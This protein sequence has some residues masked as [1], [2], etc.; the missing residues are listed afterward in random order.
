M[1]VNIYNDYEKDKKEK[2]DKIDKKKKGQIATNIVDESVQKENAQINRNLKKYVNTSEI[3]RDGIEQLPIQQEA[4]NIP[5]QNEK[6]AE[7]QVSIGTS[8]IQQP[9]MVEAQNETH[10]FKQR[11]SEEEVNKFI[12]KPLVTD[13]EVSIHKC[14]HV[15]GNKISTHGKFNTADSVCNICHA[16]F[17]MKRFTEENLLLAQKDIN[18][19]IEQLKI[20]GDYDDTDYNDLIRAQVVISKIVSEYQKL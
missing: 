2:F 6:P 18:D 16:E 17:N 13:E 12:N 20:Y 5:E 10:V 9:E 8:D 4:T 1:K 11:L 19:A 7:Q 3:N 14:N 15:N